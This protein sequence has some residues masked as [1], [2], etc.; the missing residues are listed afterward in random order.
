MWALP[1]LAMIGIS[2][3]GALSNA[4]KKIAQVP[5]GESLLGRVVNSLDSPLDGG[6]AI[7]PEAERLIEI[8]A[9]G[10]IERRGV[11]QPLQTGIKAIDSM[12]PVGRGQR[13]LII[14]DRRTG[15]TAIAIDTI[16]IKR[17]RG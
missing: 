6:G 10:V 13:E 7:T 17:V 9:P 8:K 14:G 12:I 5:A 1:S 3:K 15:K 4:L 11:H 2:K 16:S